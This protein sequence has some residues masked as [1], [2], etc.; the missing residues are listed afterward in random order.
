[1]LDP[2]HYYSRLE[3][4]ELANGLE[5][6][7]YLWMEEPMDEH[8][9]SSYVWLCEQTSLPICGPET[10]EGKM[11]VRAEWIKAGACDMVRSGVGDVGGI[12]GLIKCVHLAEAF[13]MHLEVHGGGVGNLHV[14][15]AMVSP[16]LYYER[17][18]LHP[19]I[20]YDAP[21]AWLNK[22]STRWTTRAS[23]TSRPTP[24]SATTSTG[25]TSTA[26]RWTDRPL[27][28]QT[29]PLSAHSWDQL[30]LSGRPWPRGGQWPRLQG[31]R[32]LRDGSTSVALAHT[33]ET[34]LG[35]RQERCRACSLP[36]ASA[37]R[38]PAP[39]VRL[40][41]F[42]PTKE[43]LAVRKQQSIPE[44]VACLSTKYSHTTIAG[45]ALI[46]SLPA[47]A[48]C[49]Y[50]AVGVAAVGDRH[51]DQQ[52]LASPAALVT[53]QHPPRA[54]PQSTQVVPRRQLRTSP[55]PVSTYCSIASKT[56]RRGPDL[57]LRSPSRRRTPTTPRRAP[58]SRR[59]SRPAE[60]APD[61]LVR[62]PVA[63]V[64]PLGP[65]ECFDLGLSK[66]LVVVRRQHVQ[67][68][69]L[70][71]A[72]LFVGQLLHKRVELVTQTHLASSSARSLCTPRTKAFGMHLEVHGGG[73][74]NLHVL[75]AMVSPGLYDER[76]LPHPFIV[77]DEPPPCFMWEQR[78]V[79]PITYRPLPLVLSWRR[80]A[81]GSGRPRSRVMADDRDARI[82]QLEAENAALRERDA[83][84]VTD[85]ERRETALRDQLAATAEVLRVIASA[86]THAQDVLDKI[87]ATAA[88]L[89]LADGVAIFRV[90]GNEIER[91]ANL[92][93]ALGTP[94]GTRETIDPGS[95][96]GRAVLERRTVRHDDAEAVVDHEYPSSAQ[97]HRARQKQHGAS[98]LRV[99]SLLVIPL[100]REGDVIGLLAVSR[101]EVQPFTDDQVRLLETFADQAVIAIENAR[102]FQ[103]IEE[104]NRRGHA[105][106]GAADRH[107]RGAPRRRV[108]A[109]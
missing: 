59:P 1:M 49:M 84:L 30:P 27:H 98:A 102:L 11:Y 68:R 26:T 92:R 56:A 61:L 83:G 41:E 72:K 50:L 109:N 97:I 6:L 39:Q 48:A 106:A 40:A 55:R 54:D 22:P 105:G 104:S 32:S 16:G 81:T 86:P 34:C 23:S 3:A 42:I 38:T 108:Q 51:D 10:A 8:S 66:R 87:V 94:R 71:F 17:G 24:A 21:P 15:G 76:G 45:L 107:R 36:R 85:A 19:F 89:C 35:R 77:W 91:V 95:W 29:V 63:P 13:G 93:P 28:P 44:N 57:S 99:R 47:N 73:V 78:R 2:F 64:R 88:R 7:G 101:D 90:D 58:A 46:P 80:R 25:T 20:D 33:Q 5:R 82:A 43:G 31:P 75:G 74:G 12:T 65:F 9:M 18:L 96:L 53:E 79:T 69:D 52:D 100:L 67:Q 37:S 70:R 60:S 62:D 4:L 103:E 14:L